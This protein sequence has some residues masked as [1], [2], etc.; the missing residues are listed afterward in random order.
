MADSVCFLSLMMLKTRDE[1]C[2]GI[3]FGA[4]FL[5]LLELCA[6]FFEEL[7]LSPPLLLIELEFSSELSYP[8]GRTGEA[9][10]CRLH[11]ISLN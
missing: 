10:L 3:N 1:A 9:C 6:N 8:L 4:E 11:V 5:I 2:S 7:L